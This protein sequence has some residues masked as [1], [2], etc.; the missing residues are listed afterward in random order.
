MDKINEKCE[1]LR[2]ENILHREALEDTTARLEYQTKV[3]HELAEANKEFADNELEY[4][5]KMEEL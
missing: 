3:N 1:N 5:S 4:K 2:K